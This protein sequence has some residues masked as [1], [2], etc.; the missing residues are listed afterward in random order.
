[1]TR[2]S[3]S[4]ALAALV[5]SCGTLMTPTDGGTGGGSGGTAITVKQGTYT[6]TQSN[7]EV[8]GVTVS[9]LSGFG[10]FG[11]YTLAA[12]TNPAPFRRPAQ[13]ARGACVSFSTMAG[14][15]AGLL[16]PGG[17]TYSRDS[18]G[19]LTLVGLAA[20]AQRTASP[21]GDGVYIHSSSE[22]D[23]RGGETLTLSAPGA[24]VPAFSQTLTAPTP[25]TVTSPSCTVAGCGSL[26]RAGALTFT[27]TGGGSSDVVLLLASSGGGQA[28]VVECRVAASAGTFT[29][30]AADMMKLPAGL[31]TVS[32]T[33]QTWTTFDAGPYDMLF[34]AELR[35]LQGPTTF[36]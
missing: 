35:P 24:T 29:V 31:G 18:A 34:E 12:G 4:V 26:S 1:M 20:G 16:A 3:L 15:D 11:T 21:N 25:V 14:A 28:G 8:G 22:N 36:Q 19:V 27:W 30:P 9:T 32:V 2:L 13:L 17:L 10:E 23:I 6:V 5:F 7:L 33:S